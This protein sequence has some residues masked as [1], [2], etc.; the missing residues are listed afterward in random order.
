[1]DPLIGAAIAVVIAW[2]SIVIAVAVPWRPP[3]K[4]MRRAGAA[5]LIVVALMIWGVP[6]PGWLPLVV[7]VGGVTVASVG[8]KHA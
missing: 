8:G 4:G 6:M 2:A 5:A 3:I 1:M 7:L